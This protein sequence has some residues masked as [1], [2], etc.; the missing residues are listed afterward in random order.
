MA[1][2]DDSTL[3]IE[4]LTKICEAVNAAAWDHLGYR[5]SCILSS[6]ALLYV[7]TELGIEAAPLRVEA[8]VFCDGPRQATILGWLGDG[9]RQPAAGPRKWRGH[10]AVVASG[11][12]LM[13]PTIDQAFDERGVKPDV[14]DVGTAFISERMTFYTRNGDASIRYK[15][16]PDKGGFKSAPDW[17][18][19]HWIGVAEDALASLAE[20]WR[21]CPGFPNYS[22]SNTGRVKRTGRTSGARP[23]MI[24]KGQLSSHGY[25]RVGVCRNRKKFFCSVHRLVAFAFIG[26]PPE[27]KTQV[28]HL[29][30]IKTD[31]RV[32]NLEWASPEDD[33]IHR[34]R[35]GLVPT[36]TRSGSYTHPERRP[37]GERHGMARLTEDDIRG[38][39]ALAQSGH[40]PKAI[41]R[42]F[43][44]SKTHA[45]RIIN[46]LSWSHV[47]QT[48]P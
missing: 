26:D 44:I 37:R 5:N 18:R 4:R 46:G 45:S 24:L 43:G 39:R 41:G 23:G 34:M 48:T 17:R 35:T 6:A 13:D 19:S 47:H 22:V 21:V 1:N 11:R 32:E 8:G 36:G 40:G 25:T 7:L 16:L 10:L 27:G 3:T 42:A 9:S 15:S 28:N 2:L 38:I 31:N 30:G 29:N 20:E 33:L 12:Y 14:V